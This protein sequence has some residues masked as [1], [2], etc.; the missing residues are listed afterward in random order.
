MDGQN[1]MKKLLITSM[2]IFATL[3]GCTSS[4]Q[5]Q[6]PSGNVAYFIKCPGGKIDACYEEAAKVC[7]GGY[8][9]ADKQASPNGVIVPAGNSMIMAK[10]PNTM[11][12]ECK[13]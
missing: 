12:V 11:L 7:P 3:S 1:A 6:G 9:F 2:A 8:T 5:I 4:R 13:Q 10:G